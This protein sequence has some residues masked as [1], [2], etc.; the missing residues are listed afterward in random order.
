[1]R[2]ATSASSA[3]LK[4]ANSKSGWWPTIIPTTLSWRT[5]RWMVL[6]FAG[7]SRSNVIILKRRG[8]LELKV[9]RELVLRAPSAVSGCKK[10]GKAVVPRPK[11]GLIC[12]TF[13]LLKRL[14]ASATTSSLAVSPKGKYFRTRKSMLAS[15]GVLNELRPKPKGREDKGNA[16]LPFESIPVK[17]FTGRPLSRVKIGATSI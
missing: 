7:T 12:A 8:E 3:V 5:C 11:T 17:G 13:A 1:M 14:N 16:S 15:I 10:P 9:E 4:F 6:I 2:S